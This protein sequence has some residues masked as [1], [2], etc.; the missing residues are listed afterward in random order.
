MLTLQTWELPSPRLQK[1]K[2]RPWWLDISSRCQRGPILRTRVSSVPGWDWVRTVRSQLPPAATPPA[3]SFPCWTREQGVLRLQA[4]TG[5]CTQKG[6]AGAHCP[7]L[8][9][10]AH[11]QI[12][13]NSSKIKLL[14]IVRVHEHAHCWGLSH[15]RP[16]SAGAWKHHHCTS[17]GK[18]R[19]S[20]R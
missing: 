6:N 8:R 18:S 14:T 13:G 15:A 9:P 16:P 7:W 10:A 5:S 12:A 20:E 11:P 1:V 4:G 2:P 19:G 17:Q 3:L